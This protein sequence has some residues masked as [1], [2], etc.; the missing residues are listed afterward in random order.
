MT[1]QGNDRTRDN[2]IRRKVLLS[3]GDLFSG[4]DLAYST[5]NLN[6]LGYFDQP[7]S[8]PSPPATT[9]SWT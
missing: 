1:I 3:D 6:N 9:G 2:V 5:R 8:R 7:T 4:E